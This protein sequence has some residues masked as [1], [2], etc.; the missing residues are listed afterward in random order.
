MFSKRAKLALIA[1]G[2]MLLS[3]CQAGAPDCAGVEARELISNIARSSQNNILVFRL[4][5]SHSDDG[6]YD[7]LDRKEY[8][9]RLNAIFRNYDQNVVN[10]V[11]TLHDIQTLSNDDVLKT[12][13]CA[14][15]LKFEIPGFGSEELPVDYSLA[16]AS[17]GVLH[18]TLGGLTF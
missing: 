3:A 4:R 5:Y 2:T 16:L 7:G 6:R 13:D 12:A 8:I 11:Y 1:A 9:A 14:A 17:D 10:G 15:I 18:G